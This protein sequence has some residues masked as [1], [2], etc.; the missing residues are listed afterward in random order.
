[1]LAIHTHTSALVVAQVGGLAVGGWLLVGC[2]THGVKK[3]QGP[4]RIQNLHRST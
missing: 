1:M 2:Q 4:F 3:M